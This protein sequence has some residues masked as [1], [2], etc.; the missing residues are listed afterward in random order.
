M[1]RVEVNCI[2][3]QWLKVQHGV[4][5]GSILGP[6]LF[7]IY[8]N[9]LPFHCNH[10]Q[11]LLFADDTNLTFP[12]KSCEE[13]Q[14]EIDK[15]R[16]WLDN[17]DLCM[18]INKTIELKLKSSE[19]RFDIDNKYI[20]IE[21]V[22]K[23]LGILVDF[24]FS[25]VSHLSVL[26]LRLSKQ[27][28]IISKLRHY[29]PGN[30]LIDYYKTNVSSI[31]QYGLIVYGCRSYSNLLPIYNLQKKILKLIYF[32]KKSDSANDIFVKN[33][34]LYIYQLRIYELLKLVL[35]SLSG[36]HRECYLYSLFSFSPSRPT[37]SASKTLLM[38]P[39]CKRM[40]EK[41]SVKF[42]ASKF[43]N[44]LSK[45]YVLLYNIKFFII[46]LRTHFWLVMKI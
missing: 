15:G 1:Q 26:K 40:I 31:I 30:Q 18:N 46:N 8:I 23:Y 16:H 44:A 22:C 39:S 10:A 25:F 11:V 45:A 32:G 3:S 35:K 21:P 37:R 17:N 7:L 38:E 24:K 34:L 27:C 33:K 29:A 12:N 13:V 2:S 36:L 5:Q 9:D 41:R 19:K 20:F 4:P 43:F 6:L 28:G 14:R 42:R